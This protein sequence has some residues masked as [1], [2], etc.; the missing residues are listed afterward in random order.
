MFIKSCFLA[1]QEATSG[2]GLVLSAILV[3]IFKFWSN[4]N[5]N[6]SKTKRSQALLGSA[7]FVS[8]SALNFYLFIYLFS[9]LS[10]FPIHNFS[11]TTLCSCT[12]Q[13]HFAVWTNCSV[14][15]SDDL[16]LMHYVSITQ[17][18]SG[19]GMW[20]SL[21]TVIFIL[22]HHGL[23]Q[24]RCVYLTPVAFISFADCYSICP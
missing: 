6:K 16:L 21:R 13:E 15:A 3:S 12:G 19:K 8:T 2:K 9:D 14:L 17:V 24:L 20:Q 5:K 10:V 4:Q 11:H 1:I 18:W 23:V 7:G 22:C